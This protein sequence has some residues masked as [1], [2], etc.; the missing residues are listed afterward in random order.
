MYAKNKTTIIT[1]RIPMI[2]NQGSEDIPE[3]TTDEIQKSISEMKNNKAPGEDKIVIEV[4]KLGGN[5]LLQSLKILFNE[6]LI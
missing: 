5:K 6:C 2:I 4:I 3:I 1:E